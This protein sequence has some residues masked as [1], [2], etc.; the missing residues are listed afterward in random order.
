MVIGHVVVVLPV[1]AVRGA[2]GRGADAVVVRG[3]GEIVG[4]RAEGDVDI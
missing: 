2:V 1:G 3:E 4:G